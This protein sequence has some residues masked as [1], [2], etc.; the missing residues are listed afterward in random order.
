[1]TAL[2]SMAESGAAQETLGSSAIAAT[3]ADTPGFL[4]MAGGSSPASSSMPPWLMSAN[5]GPGPATQWAG[6]LNQLKG[7][8][9]QGSGNMAGSG[10]PPLHASIPASNLMGPAPNYTPPQTATLGGGGGGG[11]GL[12]QLLAMLQ[13]MGGR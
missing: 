1:M 3:Q 5:G 8:V 10:P 9:P 12:Q 7:L 4:A 11:Q 13:K 6:V 2:S